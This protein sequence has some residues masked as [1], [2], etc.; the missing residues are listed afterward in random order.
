MNFFFQVKESDTALEDELYMLT[1]R[2]EKLKSANES[3][4]SQMAKLMEDID[5]EIR[6]VEKRMSYFEE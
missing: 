6:D 1:A 5:N 3:F 2:L 4:K